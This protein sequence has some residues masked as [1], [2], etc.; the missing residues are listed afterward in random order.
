MHQIMFRQ[1]LRGWIY[2]WAGGQGRRGGVHKHGKRWFYSRDLM[3]QYPDEAFNRIKRSDKDKWPCRTLAQH[4]LIKGFSAVSTVGPSAQV[5]S[6]T[7]ITRVPHKESDLRK[8]ID[9]TD[10]SCDAFRQRFPGT[11]K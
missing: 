2:T 7:R 6:S 8:Q 1:E 4:W 11:S 3:L 10:F 5:T 9:F